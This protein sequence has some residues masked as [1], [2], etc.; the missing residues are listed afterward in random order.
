MNTQFKNARIVTEFTPRSESYHPIS[1]SGFKLFAKCPRHYWEKYIN[2]DHVETE[3]KTKALNYG[4]AL[5]Y[6]IESPEAFEK[7]YAIA[8]NFDRRTKEGKAA[9]EAFQFDNYGKEIITVEEYEAIKASA[10]NIK[11]DGRSN[12][13][14]ANTIGVE[15]LFETITPEKPNPLTHIP[16]V[17]LRGIL[18]HLSILPNTEGDLV[19]T[20]Y[21]SCEDASP[22]AVA[23][24]CKNHG[25]YNQGAIYLRAFP[26][27]TA[28]IFVF[29][30]KKAPYIVEF[31]SMV[32]DS[33]V[34]QV[35]DAYV[36][37]K[38]SDF[39]ACLI[40][41]L[42]D[43]YNNDLEFTELPLHNYYGK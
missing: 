29:I 37:G 17:Y 30:E 22:D 13:F 28:V 26:E 12:A 1:P 19:I 23:L 40:T 39:S 42:W 27:A 43:T 31:Y 32:R 15:L 35:A 18:D 2:P 4:S 41:G 21:K 33:K 5:H 7:R 16:N 8:Q 6:F 34:H 20:D 38:L 9:F 36:F 11:K 24:A 14:L 10:T 3:K 25:Y